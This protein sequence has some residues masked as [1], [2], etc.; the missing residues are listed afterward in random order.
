MRTIIA[1]N[2]DVD[3][4]AA[5]EAILGECEAKLAGAEPKGV[6]L[7]MT[8]EY[9]YELV[10]G[11]I[12]ARWPRVPLVGAS[13]D[14][15]LSSELGF[16]GD[17]I[18]LTLLVG[19]ELEVIAGHGAQPSVDLPAAIESVVASLEGRKPALCIVLCPAT[20]G[21]PSA[22]IHA[23]HERLGPGACPI[24]GG[25]AGDHEVQPTTRQF[26]GATSTYDSLSVLFLSGPIQVSCGVASGWFP[27]GTKHRVTRSEG[28]KLYEIDGRPALDIYAGFW[29]NRV[30]ANL[31]EYPLAVRP[32]EDS[33]EFFL[34]AAMA[35]DAVE[36]SVTFAGDIVEGS[37]VSL[38]EVVPE[39]LLT[40]TETSIRRAVE[41]YTGEKPEMALLFSCAARKWVLGSRA[42]DEIV[43]L[44]KSIDELRLPAINL[45]GFYAFGE[46]CPIESGG[47]P[48]L[49]NETCVTV[50]VG[51]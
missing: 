25:L 5:I 26:F 20:C 37:I 1:H 10:L 49:H 4:L 15:Q 18:C 33:E 34:R 48:M 3:S 42:E 38:T 31:G 46:I 39:G 47:P 11:R 28:N 23:L 6:L 45:S 29:G 43:Q 2:D 21:N 36:G 32:S 50:L 44:L 9:D 24:V 19:D 41:H 14:G 17:S 27:I 16:R 12:H 51:K 8:S 40:G 7:F 13:T 30:T 35:V 22:V